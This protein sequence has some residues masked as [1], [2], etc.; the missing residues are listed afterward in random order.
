MVYNIL[1]YACQISTCGVLLEIQTL[2]RFWGG[3]KMTERQKRMKELLMRSDA[4]ITDQILSAV[5]AKCDTP[6]VGST[7]PDPA[8]GVCPSFPKS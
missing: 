2:V 3:A 4:E 8:P 5:L 7:R 6:P 1:I